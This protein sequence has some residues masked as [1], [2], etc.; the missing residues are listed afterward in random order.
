MTE[1]KRIQID[2]LPRRPTD[3]SR[4]TRTVPKDS[5][6]LKP[7]FLMQEPSEN[8]Y[9]QQQYVPKFFTLSDGLTINANNI[10]LIEPEEMI[11]ERVVHVGKHE[12]VLSVNEVNQLLHFLN[13]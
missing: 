7:E 12:L 4:L 2:K 5:A 3:S 10:D 6:P 13:K 8:P 9:P 11:G 1:P